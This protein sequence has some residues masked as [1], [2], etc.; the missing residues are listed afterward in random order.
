MSKFCSVCKSVEVPKD[1]TYCYGCTSA[2][3]YQYRIDKYKKNPYNG[4]IYVVV[5]PAWEG[6]VKVGRAVD[7]DARVKS[8]NT[9]SPFRDYEAV[10]Y[11]SIENPV[12]I[13]RYFTENYGSENNEWFNLTIECAIDIIEKLKNEYHNETL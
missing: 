9:S 4:F 8:Y 2:K 13:E 3:A 5:N 7:V 11:T 6:W 10:Y 1:R 12:L